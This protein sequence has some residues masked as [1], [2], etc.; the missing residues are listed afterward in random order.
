MGEGAG[1]RPPPRAAPRPLLTCGATPGPEPPPPGGEREAGAASGSRDTAGGCG[2]GPGPGGGGVPV[3]GTVAGPFRRPGNRGRPR[4]RA[5]PG[6][7]M[8]AE[9]GAGGQPGEAL[10]L[11]GCGAAPAAS[12]DLYRV[13][14]RLLAS[15]AGFVGDEAF[16]SSQ[17]C[18]QCLGSVARVCARC[19]WCSPEAGL[20]N[21][22]FRKLLT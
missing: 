17:V 10:A 8:E 3:A 11:T 7:E 13:S 5:A 20:V 19:P 1:G 12:G 16:F 21:L 4:G 18:A 6:W 22:C 9:P 15:V 14:V 2:A